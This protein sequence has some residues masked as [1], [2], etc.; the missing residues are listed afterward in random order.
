MISN[1]K[2]AV[3][4]LTSLKNGTKLDLNLKTPQNKTQQRMTK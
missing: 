3:R 1:D 4:S 2:S